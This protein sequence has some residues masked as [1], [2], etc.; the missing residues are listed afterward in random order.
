MLRLYKKQ[1]RVVNYEVC[2]NHF[3]AREP[4]EVVGWTDEDKIN[5]VDTLYG[6]PE[7]RTWTDYGIRMRYININDPSDTQENIVSDYYY[8]TIYKRVERR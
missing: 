1:F 3:S 5:L 4:V 7:P 8:D 2:D 6:L